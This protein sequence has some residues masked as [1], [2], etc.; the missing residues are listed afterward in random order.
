[1]KVEV[2]VDF[3]DV[4]VPVPVLV[5]TEVADL[6]AAGFRVEAEFEAEGLPPLPLALWVVFDL[7][8]QV[9]LPVERLYRFFDLLF[10]GGSDRRPLKAT[11]RSLASPLLRW[12]ATWCKRSPRFPD[13][14]CIDTGFA[15]EPKS[16]PSESVSARAW[17]VKCIV[18]E[19]VLQEDEEKRESKTIYQEVILVQPKER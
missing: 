6:D 19:G 12:S 17:V 14:P 3:E 2:A 11:R 10:A 13:W 18:C 5:A 4:A 16:W 8:V 7:A 1:L 15:S 9:V